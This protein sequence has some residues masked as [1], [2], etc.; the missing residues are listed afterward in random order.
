M[1]SV[2][3]NYTFYDLWCEY[4]KYAKLNFKVQSYRKISSNFKLHIL[5]FFKDYKLNSIDN[6]VFLDWQEKIKNKGFKNSYNKNLHSTMVMIFN[7]ALKHDYINKNI[8]SICG[9]I[10]RKRFERKNVNFWTYEEYLKFNSIINDKLYKTLFETLYFTGIRIGECL[11]LTWD[12]LE[13]NSININ[14]TISKEHYENNKYCI[15]EPKTESSYRIIQLNKS[16]LE[17]LQELYIEYN[18]N[19]N[20][21]KSWFIFGGTKP[22]SRT[23]INRR[24]ANYCKLSNIKKIRLHDFRHSHATLLLS[25]GVPI[26]AISQRLGHSDTSLTLNTYAHLTNKDTDKAVDFLNSLNATL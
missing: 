14:K 13:N 15:N 17:H 8:A 21:V 25:N 3:N 11:A 2:K 4:D 16:L 9:N 7:Y 6:I 12:D 10:R 20:F 5:P 18:K 19:D 26:K 23:T 22:L 1:E 24:L